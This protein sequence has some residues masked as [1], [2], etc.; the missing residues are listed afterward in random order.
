MQYQLT[1]AVKKISKLSKRIRA[2]SGGTGAAK[3]A[4]ILQWHIDYAQTHKGEVM[5]IVSESYP[6]LDIGVIAEFKRIMQGHN[7][8]EDKRWNGGAPRSYTFE[9]GTVIQFIT[10]DSVGKAH[11]PRR[12]VLYLNEANNLSWFIVEQLITRTK[13][14]IFMDWN[15]SEDFWFD[16]EILNKRAD[17]DFMGD[18]GNYPPL[19][20]LDNE[21]L[22]DGQKNEILARKNNP[23]W[24]RVY[25]LGLKGQLEGKIYTNW[26]IVD[27]IPHEARLERYGLDFGYTNDPTAIVGV[28]YYNGGYILD[29]VTF[30]KGLSN[31]Q[32]ADI[33]LNH[34]KGLVIADSAEPKSIDE[35]R[36]YGINIQPTVKGK[37]S[38]KN[39]I[40]VVQDQQ[41]SV[42]KRSVNVI[43]EYRNYLWQTDR[44]G[45]VLN[46]PEPLWDHAMD[47]IRYAIT[48]L[49]PIKRREEIINSLPPVYR[50]PKNNPAR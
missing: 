9:T 19:T 34:R 17:V 8:W 20:F 35:I 33:I 25:G 10:F 45:R 40:Q 5:D 37:D 39:G 43:K 23:N 42:T 6:H 21:G 14:I 4:G 7:Y 30:Q 31:K 50:E 47:A 1:T 38:I 32:I 13:K 48:S 49:A 28:Y 46:E 27:E 12:D 29:E 2:I 22:D 16:E 26:Q 41:I 44:D 15:P 3:T 24:W 11:G 18:G 36:S